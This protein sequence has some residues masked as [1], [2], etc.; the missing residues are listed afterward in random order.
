MIKV[1]NLVIHY[2]L[3]PIQEDEQ[4]IGLHVFDQSEF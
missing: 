3:A 4:I 2:F 1:I